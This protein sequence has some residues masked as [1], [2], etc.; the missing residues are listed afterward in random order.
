MKEV[1][2]EGQLGLFEQLGIQ[3]TR[4]SEGE[5]AMLDLTKSDPHWIEST[6]YDNVSERPTEDN[7]TFLSEILEKNV[8][9]KYYLSSKACKGILRRAEER[10]KELPDVLRA[11]LLGQAYSG[12]DAYGVVAKGNG[13]T[14]VQ[15]EQHTTLSTGGGKPGQGYP[16]CIKVAD[17]YNGEISDKESTLGVN[18]GIP[19][20][21]NAVLSIENHAN[22]S[23]IKFS[24]DNKV[25]TLS[26][27]MGT[28]GNNE[29]MVLEHVQTDKDDK[30]GALCE[31]DTKGAGSQYVD[32]N[33]CVV[34]CI[35]C[36]EGNGTRPSH[37]GSGINDGKTA[38]TLNTTEEHAVV[39]ASHSNAFTNPYENVAGA[40]TATDYKDPPI[41][42]EPEKMGV[43]NDQGGERI[44]IEDEDIS[45][46]L[47]AETHGHPPIVFS[48][49]NSQS[50]NI[51]ASEDISPSLRAENTPS[52]TVFGIGS[53]DSNGMKSDNPKAGIYE[54]E[55]SKTLDLT[56][57]NPACN[58]G[59]MAI[60]SETFHKKSHAKK[61]GEGQGWERTDI[62]DTLNTFD[63][64]EART[65]TLAV[66]SA[67]TFQQIKY[68]KYEEDNV[69][70]TLKAKGGNFHGG[71]ETLIADGRKYMVRRLTPTE[72]ARLQGLPDYWVKDLEDPEPSEEELDIW[73]GIF[74]DYRKAITHA[75]KPK[76]RAAVKKFLQNPYSDSAAYKMF[77]NGIA[78]WCAVFVFAGIVWA[79]ENN[80]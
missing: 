59:G 63:Q 29:P 65:P 15:E 14:F 69:G 70:A 45:P 3:E 16:C 27:R 50:A 39:T 79:E 30:C 44:D 58:Q 25:Q 5:F 12:K 42:A 31:A 20:G 18:C 19:T 72:C 10:G 46:T 33:K 52:V 32:Q 21:R 77:G 55:T 54:A 47:R 24:K 74:E 60:V 71:S 36:I 38:Y 43:L 41:V 28:G 66:D 67:R 26:S 51:S 62:S 2:L 61:K 4:V 76:A 22:D 75:D 57:G 23:R 64:G 73:E 56:G 37:K 8:D 53:K 11:A 34:E 78:V 40:L 6:P 13:E 1:K 49:K 7:P 35:S 80:D 68:D 9:S 17:P 48:D